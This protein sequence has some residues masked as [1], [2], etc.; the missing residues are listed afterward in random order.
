MDNKMWVANVEESK[1]FYRNKNKSNEKMKQRHG[2][3][4]IGPVSY[5][6]NLDKYEPRDI[7]NKKA[8][9]LWDNQ[10]FL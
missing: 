7:Y 9:P 10:E 3:D 5:S 4:D 1:D 6:E 2:A 8:A